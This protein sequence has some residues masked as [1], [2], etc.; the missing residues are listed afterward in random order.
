M[1]RLLYGTSV[2]RTRRCRASYGILRPEAYNKSGHKGHEPYLNPA[3]NR[4]YVNGHIEWFIWK[5][6]IIA[7]DEKLRMEL[8]RIASF[9]NPDTTWVDTIVTSKLPPDC[10]PRYLGEGDSRVACK[11]ASDSQRVPDSLT[12]KRNYMA[13]GKKFLQGS[14]E[15]WGFL[16]Q[17]NIRFETMVNGVKVGAAQTLQVPWEYIRDD[18]ST[19]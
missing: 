9:E 15:I 5:G 3:D 8:T 11:I 18:E 17:E 16:E 2:L 19:Q 10:L 4:K 1:Q 6:D 7:E 14:Y 12:S 13:F